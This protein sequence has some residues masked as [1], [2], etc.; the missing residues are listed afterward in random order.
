MKAERAVAIP[1]GFLPFGRIRW[2]GGLQA[3]G[4]PSVIHLAAETGDEKRDARPWIPVCGRRAPTKGEYV[5]PRA[6]SA[7]VRRGD[8]RPCVRCWT[9]AVAQV[10]H[11][12]ALGRHK[13]GGSAW[14]GG[15]NWGVIYKPSC[16]CGEEWRGAN[17]DL[18]DAR[19][20]E[21]EHLEAVLFEGQFRATAPQYP[22]VIA[23]RSH[24]LG[25]ML[26]VPGSPLDQQ[27]VELEVGESIERIQD[28]RG[29]HAS[30]WTVERI[31]APW[32]VAE[33]E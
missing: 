3:G 14:R 33:E 27:L 17:T 30:F 31:A 15:A 4:T 10:G 18:R 2:H 26:R 19:A 13:T 1:E 32:L 16:S 28:G 24:V 7:D 25:R 11:R 12:F 21:R 22:E 23:T 20:I 5:G 6:A 9:V 29:S 8:A